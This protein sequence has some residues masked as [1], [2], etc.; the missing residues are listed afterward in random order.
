MFKIL[1]A[2]CFTLSMIRANK[3]CTLNQILSMHTIKLN[4]L[5]ASKVLRNLG[6]LIVFSI[7]VWLVNDT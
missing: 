5:P 7:G 3:Q 6:V 2:I 4:V 1:I